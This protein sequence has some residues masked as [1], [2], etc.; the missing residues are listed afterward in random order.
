MV[1]GARRLRFAEPCHLDCDA[2]LESLD[3]IWTNGRSVDDAVDGAHLL[4]ALD[5]VNGVVLVRY[6][7]ELLRAHRLEKLRQ[8]SSQPRP[9][10]FR[11]GGELTASLNDVWI[12]LGPGLHLTGEDDGC[13]WRA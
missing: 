13:G 4:G 1:E 5:V 12:G 10:R 2:T 9:V 7:A 3:E 8:L 6:L 11:C